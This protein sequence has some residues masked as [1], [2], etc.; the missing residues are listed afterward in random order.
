M[1]IDEFSPHLQTILREMCGRVETDPAKI[2]FKDPKWFLGHSWTKE[3]E[4]EFTTWLGD[5][6]HSNKEARQEILETRWRYR[7]KKHCHKAAWQF[8]WNYGWKTKE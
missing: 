4:E 7:E 1:K 3:I 6:L 8:D 5:Y 2:D